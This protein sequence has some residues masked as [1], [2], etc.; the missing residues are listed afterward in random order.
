VV[1]HRARQLDEAKAAYEASSRPTRT[2]A[3]GTLNLGAVLKAQ[4]QVDEGIA[5]Y[6]KPSRPTN[7][8]AACSTT[9]RCSTARRSGTRRHRP[10]RKL[11]DAR[12]ENLD[13]Y[14]NLALVYYDQKQVQADPD[15]PGE[16]LLKMATKLNVKDPDIYVNLG[17]FNLALGDNGKAMAAFKKAVE[18]QPTHLAGQL[19][20]RRAGAGAP[21]LRAWPCAAT[22]WSARLGRSG[23]TWPLLWALRTKA[24]RRTRRPPNSWPRPGSWASSKPRPQQRRRRA[25]PAA[26]DQR[27]PGGGRRA[28]K[29]L[30][31]YGNELLKIKNMP[32]CKEDDFEGLCGRINGIL[33]MK[34]MAA[35]PKEEEKKVEAKG[36]GESLFKDGPAEG[37]PGVGGT[38]T[39]TTAAGEP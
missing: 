19:Q 37:D 25:D 22:R 35:Q 27:V 26:A 4:G 33:I 36:T 10:I 9:S 2:T 11:L 29:A 13:A 8:T 28:D 7:T 32:P 31:T 34:K 14:K 5:L 12:Q 23:P 6:V 21:R 30:Q 1:L 39:A 18:I 15:H 16:R 38:E 24:C 17:M 3:R 20:H